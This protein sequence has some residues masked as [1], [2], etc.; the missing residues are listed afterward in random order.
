EQGHFPA[1]DLQASISRVMPNLADAEQLRR[2]YKLK[3]LDSRYASQQDLI[4]VG[5]YTPGSDPNLDLAV[6]AHAGIRSFLRQ[7]MHEAVNLPTSQSM[8]AQLMSP[9]LG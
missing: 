2:M 4:A 7:G 9:Y 8:L 3:E 6:Q 5:A 1:I